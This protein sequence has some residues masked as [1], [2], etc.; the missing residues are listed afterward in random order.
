MDIV[1]IGIIGF[2]HPHV[3]SYLSVLLERSDVRVLGGWDEDSHRAATV[4][5]PPGLTVYDTLDALLSSDINAVIICS[6]N[7]RHAEW[8]IAAAQWGKHVLCEKPLG[9]TMKDMN[10]M[11]R[12]CREAGVQLMTAFPCRY[13]P[14]V[15]EAKLTVERGEIGTVLAIKGTNRGTMPGSWFVDPSLS[16]G[17]AVLDHTVHVMDLMRWILEDEP[18]VVYAEMGRLFY[19]ELTVEDAGLVHVT[20]RG[21]QK[22]V[23]DTSWSRG[24]SFP[25][26]GD[27]AMEIIGTNGMLSI[28]VY[29]QKN[30]LYCDENARAEWSYWGDNP[31]KDLI[32]D[33]VQSIRLG[34]PATITGEDGLAAAAVALAAYESARLG[35]PVSMERS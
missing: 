7:V 20:F 29:A 14:A 15:R 33:F 21:G 13:F 4:L 35:V 22:T 16:G 11:V 30:E 26:Q 25:M 34:T 19:D 32:E 8:T 3:H 10:D 17:G 27:V 31:D 9:T 1:N 5:G 18:D 23:L 2:A 6:E 24:K 28:D 12:A